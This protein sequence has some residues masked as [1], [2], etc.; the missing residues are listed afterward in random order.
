MEDILSIVIIVLIAVASAAK[1]SKKK[2]AQKQESKGALKFSANTDKGFS[3]MKEFIKDVGKNIVEMD[4]DDDYTAP[5]KM[6]PAT[7]KAKPAAKPVRAASVIEEGLGMPPPRSAQGTGLFE[8][9][10]C[11]SGSIAHDSHEGDSN[12]PYGASEGAYSA[13]ES[14][15]YAEDIAQ[16]LHSMNVQRLRRAIVVSEILDKPKALRRR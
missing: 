15:P 9:K 10:G 4:D 6:K 13:G 11:I 1:K 12:Y 16:E 8:S 14:S 7:M 5:A 3:E 2:N